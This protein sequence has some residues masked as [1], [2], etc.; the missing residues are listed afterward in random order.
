MV[1]FEGRESCYDEQPGRV[2]CCPRN[3][4]KMSSRRSEQGA[5]AD[6]GESGMKNGKKKGLDAS[7]SEYEG[8]MSSRLC[9][10]R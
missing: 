5:R 10:T 1:T 8:R 7:A 9:R 3:G 4:E 2:F 6:S